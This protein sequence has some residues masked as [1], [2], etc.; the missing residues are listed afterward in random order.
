MLRRSKTGPINSLHEENL[1]LCSF[2]LLFRASGV[3]GSVN[4][5]PIWSWT[6]KRSTCC[7]NSFWR[8]RE[9]V[10]KAKTIFGEGAT[11]QTELDLWVKSEIKTS[12]RCCW[13]CRRFLSIN[14][15]HPRFKNRKKFKQ[16]RKRKKPQMGNDKHHKTHCHTWRRLGMGT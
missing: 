11:T 16:K 2:S 6:L 5:F 15:S 1:F 8:S 12:S 4:L 14:P 10:V 3:R 7:R 9:R 13:R